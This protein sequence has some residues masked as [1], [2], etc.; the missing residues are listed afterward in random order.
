MHFLAAAAD[1]AGFFLPILWAWQHHAA[2]EAA[3]EWLH[4]LI[5]SKVELYAIWVR[6]NLDWITNRCLW[7]FVIVFPLLSGAGRLAASLTGL[8]VEDGW[9][10]VWLI[11]TV[12]MELWAIYLL[13]CHFWGIRHLPLGAIREVADGRRTVADLDAEY[14]RAGSVGSLWA[15]IG[16]SGAF[17]LL[18]LFLFALAT[19]ATEHCGVA[20]IVR[21]PVQAVAWI[22][23]GLAILILATP[24]EFLRA[25]MRVADKP[26]DETLRAFSY[27]TAW[28]P[29][30]QGGAGGNTAKLAKGVNV[31]LEKIEARIAKYLVGVAALCSMAIAVTVFPYWGTWMA[32]PLILFLSAALGFI[33]MAFGA[34]KSMGKGMSVFAWGVAFTVSAFIV[35]LVAQAFGMFSMR[36]MAMVRPVNEGIGFINSFLH[37]DGFTPVFV[38]WLCGLA[39]IVVGALLGLASKWLK[40]VS[41][42]LAS[43]TL[44]VMF[45]TAWGWFASYRGHPTDGIAYVHAAPPDPPGGWC[46]FAAAEP[47]RAH[48]R[49]RHYARR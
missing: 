27:L 18:A 6:R 38:T 14:G 45:A 31:P 40:P 22:S 28:F 10:V 21:A 44:V 11:G 30:M 48:R 37:P 46:Q 7:W 32:S 15:C 41:W 36:Q 35:V 3:R 23:F 47:R 26:L 43:I 17:G 4:E 13:T 16:M 2:L 19:H 24:I 39:I 20:A 12:V 8:P 5:M 1:W 29:G 25:V 33:L 34:G 9:A 49:R 42:L